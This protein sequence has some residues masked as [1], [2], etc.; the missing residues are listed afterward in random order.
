MAEIIVCFP[1]HSL[2]DHNFP[3]ASKQPHNAAGEPRKNDRHTAARSPTTW[4]S[5]RPYCFHCR[6]AGHLTKDCHS[7]QSSSSSGG[8]V[9]V[10]GMM[11]KDVHNQGR[12]RR[13]YE[14]DKPDRGQSSPTKSSADTEPPKCIKCTCDSCRMKDKEQVA[15]MVSGR[16]LDDCCVKE[17]K[18]SLVCG[19]V[20]PVMGATFDR[21]P[22]MPV[23]FLYM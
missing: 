15:C 19:H 5:S 12:R 21:S 14:K 18:V 17:G 1:P 11:T 4:N 3:S 23:T 9:K 10:A 16:T 22:N 2:V 6:R 13:A 8:S 7:R 20:L